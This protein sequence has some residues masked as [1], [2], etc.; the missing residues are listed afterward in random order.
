MDAS[1]KLSTTRRWRS[2]SQFIIATACLAMFTESLLAGFPV[3]ML[4]YMLEERLH[5]DPSQT[6]ATINSLLSLHGLASILAA[7]SCA[8]LFDT[9]SNQKIPLY[10]ALVLCLAGTALFA[11]TTTS[12]VLYLG[13]ILQA[14]AASAAWLACTTMLTEIAG[15]ARAGAMLG[16]SMSF[17]TLGT[18][19][20]PMF[21]GVLLGW[22]GY[23]PAWCLPMALLI[24]DM[25][26]RFV[27]IQPDHFLLDTQSSTRLANRSKLC[28]NV[29]EASPFLPQSASFDQDTNT[30]AEPDSTATTEYRN[31][32]TVMLQDAG[33]WA[34]VLN[35]M[36]QAA[37]RAAFNA[38]LPVYLRDTFNWGPSSVGAIFF[39][40]QVPVIFLPPLFGHLRDRVGTRYPTAVGWALLC[41]LMCY[42]GVPGRDISQASGSRTDAEVAFIVCICGIG[43]VMSSVQGAGSF[44]MRFLLEEVEKDTP[45]LFGPNGGRARCF[46]LVSISFNVGLML[47]PVV[48]GFLFESAG[49]FYMNIALGAACMG[50]ALVTFMF[51]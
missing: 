51:C 35:T 32:Y 2:S 39:A 3:P 22:F 45:T 23:W 33:M 7:P 15:S 30:K 25:I 31:Y 46:A 27:M 6:T 26:A 40:L 21:G 36:S 47:G 1:T 48:T 34:A 12:W 20:G 16:L 50:V 49:Y 18:V 43:L 17:S 41:P 4:P 13:R 28:Q 42:L 9:I 24:L 14:V 19:S 29:P 5:N 37:V 10:S 44:H 38:T 11:I 8:T